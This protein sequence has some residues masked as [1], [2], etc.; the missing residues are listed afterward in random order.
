MRL[1]PRTHAVRIADNSRG[2]RLA[3]RRG[4]G[5]RQLRIH[6]HRAV[7]LLQGTRFGIAGHR[8]RRAT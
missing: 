7:G 5:N 8:R 3:H 2:A 1:K 6:R 4:G